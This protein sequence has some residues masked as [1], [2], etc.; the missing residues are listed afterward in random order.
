MISGK[1][2]AQLEAI[3]PLAIVGSNSQQQQIDALIDTGFTGGLT[4]RPSFI[5]ALQLT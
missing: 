4:L 1:V 2:N 5:A 3:L